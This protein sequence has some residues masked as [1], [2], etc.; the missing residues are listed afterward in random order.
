MVQSKNA[1]NKIL[2]LFVRV[3]EELKSFHFSNVGFSETTTWG[4]SRKD[5]A[6]KVYK[7]QIIQEL[8]PL[9]HSQFIGV[10]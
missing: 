7:V 1:V 2:N 3:V 8:K 9:D 6:L 5:L 4:M 10:S